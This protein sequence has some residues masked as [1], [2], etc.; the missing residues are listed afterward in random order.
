MHIILEEIEHIKETLKH[1]S[2]DL[3][4]LDKTYNQI[5][6]IYS[7]LIELNDYYNEN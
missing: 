3:Y 6:T 7:K 5:Q 4:I 1:H 2:K